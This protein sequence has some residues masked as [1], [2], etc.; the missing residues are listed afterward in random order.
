MHH[1]IAAAAR[2]GNNVIAD[3]VLIDPAWVAECARPFA[4]MPAYLIGIRCPIEI[5]EQRELR[6]TN[7]IPG[8]ARAQFE[9]VHRYAKY[10][11][12]LDTS[13]L[14]PDECAQQLIARLHFAPVA[15][16]TLIPG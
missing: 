10:D 2:Q 11:L 3:H 8:Q 14:T 7:R 1:A 6:R 5:I 13:L 15:F 16:K 4:R 12:E 9:L